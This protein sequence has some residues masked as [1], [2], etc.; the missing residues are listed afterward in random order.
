MKK[1][2]SLMLVMALAF[3]L[4]SCTPSQRDPSD[5]DAAVKSQLPKEFN[6]GS[7]LVF[8]DSY[9][10][11]LLSIEFAEKVIPAEPGN[12]Y[13]Y[14][15]VDDPETETYLHAI[16]E[17]KNLQRYP[18]EANTVMKVRLLHETEEEYPFFSAV[19]QEGDFAYDNVTPIAPLTTGVIHYLTQL[20]L[21]VA[22]GDQPLDIQIEVTGHKMVCPVAGTE[23]KA[24]IT[25]DLGGSP[26]EK[27]DWQQYRQLSLEES[28]ELKYHNRIRIMNTLFTSAIKPAKPGSS[29][30][31]FQIDNPD[32][33]YLDVVIEF[34]NT[35]EETQEINTV[36]SVKAVYDDLYEYSGFA[37]LEK[38]DGSDFLEGDSA[39]IPAGTK[40]TLHYIF[41]LPQELEDSDRPLTL[42][43]SD[44]ED[45]VFYYQIRE[46]D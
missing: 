7:T 41:T 28:V 13:S 15:E 42:G 25:L 9:E 1:Y 27:T 40:A 39:Q 38:E 26:P 6:K 37:V 24:T 34:E 46:N 45:L 4:S 22:E 8:T 30:T 36:F 33:I 17:I 3:C 5:P 35:A 11:T 2:L 14:Y 16:F 20:P 19:E 18:K 32:R 44:D 21:E 31:E 43:I 29:Y 12:F 10:I 23:K